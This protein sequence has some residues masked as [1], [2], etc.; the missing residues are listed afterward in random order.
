[1]QTNYNETKQ[2]Q[3]DW[4]RLVKKYATLPADFEN[5]KK[6]MHYVDIERN[7]KFAYLYKSENVV[8]IKARLFCRSLKRDSLRIIYAQRTD[9]TVDLVAIDFIEVY[10]K[11]DK[12]R[13]DEMRIQEYIKSN[14]H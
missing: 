6:R 5:F 7:A 4:K 1:M 12:V 10:F 11:G 3:K 13:E 14:I 2:F 9:G 8:I